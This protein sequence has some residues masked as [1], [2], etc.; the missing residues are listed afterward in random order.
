MVKNAEKNLDYEVV[1]ELLKNA[2]KNEKKYSPYYKE[3]FIFL[4]KLKI[5][6]NEFKLSGLN[7]PT[8]PSL[9]K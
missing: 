8:V 1:F 9:I 7:F 4:K 2:K 5:K 3:K 6:L